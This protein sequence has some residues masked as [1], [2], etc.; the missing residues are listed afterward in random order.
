M[1]GADGIAEGLPEA[2]RDMQIPKFRP[3]GIRILHAGG[4]A[5]LFSAFLAGWLSGEGGSQTVMKEIAP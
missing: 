4:G 5:G 2:V 1:R 3:D